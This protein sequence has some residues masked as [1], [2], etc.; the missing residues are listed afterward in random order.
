MKKVK[1]LPLLLYI[2]VLVLA[3]SFIWNLFAS[4]GDGLSYAQVVELFQQEK[5]ES[6]VVDGDMIHLQ[7][8]SEYAGKTSL[9][10]VLAD[11]DGFRTEML[12]LLLEQKEK[13]VL[14]DFNFIAQEGTTPFDYVLPII[15]AQRRLV[16][17]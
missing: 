17:R 15:L 5:V 13:G 3:F 9:A 14:K 10:T 2:A 1:I 11:P 16:S 6:F 8:N 4:G 12:P 7:L